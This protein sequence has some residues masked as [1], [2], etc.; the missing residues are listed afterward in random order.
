MALDIG[1]LSLPF[2]DHNLI[3]PFHF[4][5]SSLNQDCRKVEVVKKLAEFCS[6]LLKLAE[7][8]VN[9]QKIKL[10]ILLEFRKKWLK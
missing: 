10:V 9:L 7:I 8:H 1:H 6:N 3:V 4:V 2:S 5:E